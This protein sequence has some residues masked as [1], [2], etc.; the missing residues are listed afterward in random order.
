M[1]AGAYSNIVT[2]STSIKIFALVGIVIGFALIAPRTYSATTMGCVD[3]STA[4][5]GSAATNLTVATAGSYNLWSRIMASDATHN[6]Y[7]LEI[8][9]G[10]CYP[11]GGND[12]L[13]NQ[14]VWVDH[15]TDST[16]SKVTVNLTAG[17]HAVRL[18]GTQP[19]VKIDRVIAVMAGKCTTGPTG[20]GDNCL[21]TIDDVVPTVSITDPASSAELSGA[22]NIKAS[23]SDDVG[24]VKVEFYVDSKIITTSTANAATYSTSWNSADASGGNHT[25]T[26]KAYDAGGNVGVDTKTIVVAQSSGDTKAPSAPASLKA[27]ISAMNTVELSWVASSDEVGVAGYTVYRDNVAIDQ[28]GA[29]TSFEDKAVAAGTAYS[30]KLVAFD[31]VGNNSAYSALATAKT[32]V[33][34]PTTQ[35]DKQAPTIPAGLGATASSVSQINLS[36]RASIDNVGVV[37]YDIYRS[38]GDASATKVASTQGIS[39]GDTGLN[40]STKYSYYIVA[41]D[42]ADNTS[43]KSSVASST[44]LSVSPTP[45]NDDSS[46]PVANSGVVRGRVV[47]SSRKPVEGVSI[48]IASKDKRYTT[49]TNTD[50]VYR[51][52]NLP[53]GRYSIVAKATDYW[54][55]RDNFR[56]KNDSEKVLN[57]HL[58][59]SYRQNNWWNRWWR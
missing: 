52:E 8:D 31:A 21:G 29:V 26:V 13:A 42:S 59:K 53:A 7:M 51:I 43:E 25:I 1:A 16:N 9:G 36:W 35:V 20:T 33:L 19:N 58:L 45:G 56:V 6:S 22:V 5:Y 18:I 37:R 40:A 48:T 30:Y 10:G 55:E 47:G 27:V 57:L 44:T 49:T 34:S 50:G 38:V 2:K 28:I 32:N 15:K 3:V 23:A 24:V 54:T 39:F 12:A 11:I 14:W 41:A 46:T 4:T 17:N